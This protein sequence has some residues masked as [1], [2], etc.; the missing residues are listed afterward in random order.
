[1]AESDTSGGKRVGATETSFAVVEQLREEGGLGVT[2]VADR[3]GISKSTAHAHLWTLVDLGYVVKEGPTYHLGLKFLDLGDHARTR[4]NLYHIAKQEVD[5]L[6][7][8]VGERGQVM[9]EENGRGVYIYQAKTERAIQTDSHIGTVVDLHATAVGKSY[10]A[11][12]PDDDLEALLDTLEL[13]ART[14]RT[15]TDRESLREELTLVR[16]RG[17]ALNDEERIAGMRAVGAPI[18]SDDG[19]VL[20]ALSVSGPTT[21]MNGEWF[22]EEVPDKVTQAARI[23]GIKATYS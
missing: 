9:V 1:M 12:L 4:Q 21:R 3:V 10:L 5:E 14:D 16:E 7:S 17:F 18:L 20:A 11:F 13:A 23:I 22:R 19:R 8:A 2:E 15:L 6:I